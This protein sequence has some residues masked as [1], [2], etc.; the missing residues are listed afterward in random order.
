MQKDILNKSSKIVIIDATINFNVFLL[1]VTYNFK[2]Y[3][4]S[5]ESQINSEPLFH[6]VEVI[7]LPPGK[8][9]KKNYQIT[10]ILKT[11]MP[12]L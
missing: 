6:S 1:V 11:I 7:I 5:K 9:Q 3:L 10:K 12:S 4:F 8:K 2:R